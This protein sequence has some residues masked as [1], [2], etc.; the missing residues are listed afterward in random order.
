MNNKDHHLELSEFARV[1]LRGRR[2]IFTALILTIGLTLLVSFKMDPVY[3]AETTI[4]IEES[5]A[6][7]TLFDLNPLLQTQTNLI[8]QMEVIKSRTLSEAVIRSIEKSPGARQFEILEKYPTLDKRTEFLQKHLRVE[9]ITETDIIAVKTRAPSSFEAAYLA[10]AIANEYYIIQTEYS[11]SSVSEVRMFLQEQ[12]D[13]IRSTLTNSEES[14]KAYKEEHNV[15]ALDVETEALV[16]QSTDF[17]SLFKEAETELEVETRK[18]ETLKDKMFLAKSTLVEDL[19]EITSPLIEQLQLQIAEKQAMIASILAK[20]TPGTSETI[21]SL[22]REIDQIK[23]KLIEEIKK[24]ASSGIAS[25]SPLKTT[26]QLFDS[27]LQ[28]EVEIKSLSAKTSALKSVVDTFSAQIERLPDKSLTLA[29]LLRETQLNE[30]I[31]LMLNE[32]YEETRIAEAGKSANVRIIDQAKPPHKPIRPNILLNFILSVFIGFGI[33]VGIAYIME[34][35]DDTLKTGTDAEKLGLPVIGAI[36]SAALDE[37]FREQARGRIVKGGDKQKRDYHLIANISPKSPIAEAYRGV[38]TNI[39]FADI[40]NPPKTILITSSSTKEGKST[41][42]AN[43]AVTFTQS[44]SRTLIIDCDMRRPTMHNFFDIEKEKG[45]SNVL[46]NEIKFEEAVS[47]T[48]IPNLFLLNSGD[49][50]PN[51]AELAASQQMKALLRKA[52]EAYDYVIIDSPPII[53]VTDALILSTE[54]DGVILTVFSGAVNKNEVLKS[55]SLLENVKAKVLG[56]LING[57]NIRKIYGSYY[58][59]T[60]YAQYYYYYDSSDKK[61]KDTI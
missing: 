61:K 60:H 28:A 11:K 52:R 4:M 56:V 40:N 2:V 32:K 41:T 3:E 8:N 7:R 47:A 55:V 37:R 14:L 59:Y 51:P 15:A 13:N 33:G 53:A 34:F 19:S 26:Q 24:I 25:N 54:A 16:K 49:I 58:Y 6:D 50:P 44:G 42:T 48:A 36:P 43:L 38:R 22:Q 1:F 29:R 45:L 20:G 39:Q 23:E 9:Q 46:I 31:Y 12:L 57:L 10:N 18:L 35:A 30:K 27:I 17:E 5:A 21:S